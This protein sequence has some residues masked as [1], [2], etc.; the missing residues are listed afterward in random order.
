[1]PDHLESLQAVLRGVTA[2]GDPSRLLHQALA[3]AVSATK[4]SE[5]AVLRVVGDATAPVATSGELSAPARATAEAAI[6]AGRLV[7]RREQGSGRTTAAE[8]LRSAGRVVGAMVVGGGFERLDP[9]ALPLY[10]AAVAILLERQP[11]AAADALPAVLEALSSVAAELD[12]R[13]MLGRIFDAADT[14]FGSTAGVCALFDGA[15]MRIAHHRGVDAKRL[16]DVSRHPEFKSLLSCPEVRVEPPA[17]PVVG[18]LA[19]LGETAVSMPLEA[20]GRRLGQLVILVASPPDAGGTSLLRSFA[21]HV[22]LCLRSAELHRSVGEREEQLSSMVHS[23]ANP[24]VVVD[25]AARIVEVNGAAAEAFHLATAFQHGEPVAGRLGNKLLEDMLGGGDDGAVEVVL[26]TEEPRV[27]RATV[28]RM[29]SD[30]GRVMGR[31]LVLDDLTRAR[32]ADALRDDFVAVIG[33]ELRTPL[34]VMKG[35]VHTLVQRWAKL[36]D[37][38]REQA[39]EAVQSNLTRLERLIEDL[40]FISAIEQRRC[41]TD[42]ALH[43]LGALLEA[44]SGERVSV[45]RPAAPVEV[46]VDK[47]KLDRVVDHLVDNALKYSEGPVVVELRAGPEHVE[48][49]VSDSGPGIFSGDVPRLFERFRQLDGSSTR[50]HGGVGIGLYIARRTVEA[51]GGRIWC[52]SRLGVGSRFAFTLPRHGAAPLSPPPSPMGAAR[53]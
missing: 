26:G 13:A 21:R 2:G 32:E 19:S 33:H 39:L 25:E 16:L 11:N 17:H 6:A 48:I 24:V 23:M 12:T 18:Q 7:R 28:R 45:Q 31:I 8:P 53:S 10:A 27:H 5:G 9:A 15:S 44:R 41:T 14:L 47:D 38:R 52:D 30:S 42:P 46:L 34:T 49:S 36:S 35:Y 1:M 51:L 50:A 37:A 43:E 22:S 3:G 29:H 4:A 40:L 20:G